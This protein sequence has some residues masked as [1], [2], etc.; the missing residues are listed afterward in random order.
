MDEL[1]TADTA[2]WTATVFFGL[3]V[4][5]LWSSIPQLLDKWLAFR[6]AKAAEKAADW[7]RIRDE[8]IRLSEAEERCRRELA[9][10]T[11]RLAEIEG[12]ELG[13]GKARQDAAN[14]V[15]LDR[16][17]NDTKEGK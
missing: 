7:T 4:V 12:Y 9:D 16:L 10:V 13:R 3:L 2:A 8:V 17:Q 1:L 14:I 11:R 6:T 5:R 15:A